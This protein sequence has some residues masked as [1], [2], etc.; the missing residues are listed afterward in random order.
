MKKEFDP[1]A[2]THTIRDLN[3]A[4]HKDRE[5]FIQSCRTLNESIQSVNER[6]FARLK[7]ASPEKPPDNGVELLM[8]WIDH[9][10]WSSRQYHHVLCDWLTCYVDEAPGLS[11]ESRKRA[12]FWVRQIQTM[13][14]PS[15]F[16]WTNPK[17]VQR[18]AK[19]KGESLNRGVRNWMGDMK[20]HHGLV[21]L[22]DQN[23]FQVGKNLAITPG[24]VVFR[25]EL[26]E[27]IQYA[28]QT[29]KVWQ[30]PIVLIQ[31]WINKFYIFD[32]SPRNSFVSFLIRQGFSVF[33]T[34]W[35][36]PG[37]DMRHI[38]FEDYMRLGA[39]QAVNVAREV[40]TCGQV[41]LA[42]YCIG[43]TLA[44]TLMGWLA[45]ETQPWPVADVTLFS[46]LVDFSEPGDLSAIVHPETIH[47]VEKLMAEKGVLED[48][49]IATAFRL[50][51]PT[52][53][54]WR[55]VGNNYF[56]G[57]PPPR[58]D[59]LYWNSDGTNLPEAM[60][61]FYLKSFYLENRIIRSNALTIGQRPINLKNVQAPFYVVGAAKDHICPWQSTFQT[62]RLLGGKVRYVLSD[63]GHITG[64][65]N[66]H[67]PWSKKKYWAGAATRMRNPEKWLQGKSHN[68]GSWWPDWI[69]WLKLR[70]GDQVPPP[71]M[72]SKTYPPLCPAP[73]TY[74]HE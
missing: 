58:S 36:N 21:A 1:L 15:N 25:N 43:G 33:I 52:D 67:S 4:W 30:T 9:L 18:F 73:G 41:H 22:A 37:P 6:V 47:S 5:A 20:A 63:E 72:G 62:C 66:P 61:N 59:M 28:P 19:T 69:N 53:L 57:E 10:S 51:N 35:K 31:P 48:H 49:Q 70:S 3:S 17:A 64:I 42:G 71:A 50:L 7:N 32:L 46:T 44:V 68:Q 60:C 45:H 34:S 74:V 27:L 11:L 13:L 55:Y 56:C 38:S 23:S 65:V 54:I 14:E 24:K 12:R 16:F 26:M 39:L 29:E 40:C 8:R 2:I